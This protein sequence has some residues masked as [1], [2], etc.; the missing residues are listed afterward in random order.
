V[1]KLGF[2]VDVAFTSIFWMTESSRQ[3]ASDSQGSIWKVSRQ[4][5]DAHERVGAVHR[6][7]VG[8]HALIENQTRS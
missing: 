4:A 6:L 3:V 8:S 7:I 5:P 2:D 1:V